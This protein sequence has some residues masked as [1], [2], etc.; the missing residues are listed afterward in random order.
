MLGLKKAPRPKTHSFAYTGFIRCG[1]CGC[2]YTAE[3]KK[4]LI[5]STDE[6][7]YYTYY[8]CTRKKLDVKC[9]QKSSIRED[10]LES[11]I[12]EILNSYTI[13]PI[14][15]DW[16]L[17]M[18]QKYH[19]NEVDEANNILKMR[20][21]TFLDIQ[22]KI[23]KL[24]DLRLNEQIGDD[25]YNQKKNSLLDEKAK[26]KH[27]LEESNRRADNWLEL[28]EKAF[29][30][31][32]NARQRF[33][34]GDVQTKKTILLTLG[35]SITALDGKLNIEESTWLTPIRQEYP[36]IE[37]EYLR[38]EPAKTGQIELGDKIFS[39]VCDKWL[40]EMFGSKNF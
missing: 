3:T 5:K 35:K 11:Q 36:E 30:F 24:L 2:L 6:F 8:H 7:R 10:I 15:K 9:S 32:A 20:Q 18:L 19:K 34:D 31:V 12:M 1:E 37:A 16:T 28:T 22:K 17:K 13:L 40:P 27:D 23:D 29:D 14:F 4:K 21:N 39:P 33:I 25:E 38:L 26:I